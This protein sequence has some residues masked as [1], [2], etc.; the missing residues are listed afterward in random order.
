MPGTRPP[1]QIIGHFFAL[2]GAALDHRVA[3]PI[4]I[5]VHPYLTRDVFTGARATEDAV[6]TTDLSGYKV[7]AFA[8]HGLVP[9]D[10]NGLRQPVSALSSPKLSGGKDDGLLIMSE[11]LS[12]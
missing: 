8:T 5:A 11:I 7:L 1:D 12:L 2:E 6:K 10:L 4:A 9:G 3:H